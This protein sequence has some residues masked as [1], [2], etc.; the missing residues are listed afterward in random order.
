MKKSIVKL[1]GIIAVS[2]SLFTSC[3]SSNDSTPSSTFVVDANKFEGT[4]KD[5]EVI[6]N[7]ATTYKLSG[8][9]LVSSGATLTIPA[10][11]RIEGTGGTASY[12]AIAQGGKIYVNGT[13]TNPVVMTSGLATKAAGDWGGLVICGKAPINI[14]SGG[15]TTAQAEVSDLT[16]GGNIA[17]DN[18]GSL[19]YL[20]IEYSGARYSPTK[21]FNALSLFGVGSGTTIDYVQL[22]HGS[23]DGIEFF[24]GTVNT[25]HLVSFG[26][27]D[28]QFDWTEGWS[29]TNSYW[30]GK[31]AFGLGNRGI[32]AD[33]YE[34]GFL[35]TPISNPTITNL[36]LVGP[37]STA[38]PL[39]YTENDGLK[40]RRGTKG[41]FT[42]VVLSGWATG[43]NVESDESIA[44]VVAGTLKATSVNF[45][46][47]IATKTKGKTTAGT[48][49]NV[50]AFVTSESSV[51]TGAGNGSAAPDWASGWALFQ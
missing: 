42:N 48:S 37:G 35:N 47:D 28:D 43:V 13:A 22:Y 1:F 9:L 33:N 18:S 25:S 36:T 21:E 45:I 46:S 5:G 27:E 34:L 15:A 50:S 2:A 10:G 4:I 30:Y 14:V 44:A 39:V 11:T 41:I 40:L 49:S 20:R 8:K 51:A 24:G 7:P 38:D 19:K 32:E 6:L 29:G 26:N 3:S 23:D 31:E 12:I 17:N 16:Y